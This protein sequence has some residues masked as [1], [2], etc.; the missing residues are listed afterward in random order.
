MALVMK[1]AIFMVKSSYGSRDVLPKNPF[2][3]E[4]NNNNKDPQTFWNKK[5]GIWSNLNN[6]C[7]GTHAYS[8]V[9]T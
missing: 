7:T 6:N 5:L 1:D 4:N 8:Q 3:Y 9:F 2:V